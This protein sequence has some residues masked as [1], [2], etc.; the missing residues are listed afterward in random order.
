MAP[1]RCSCNHKFVIFKLISRYLYHFMWI[2]LRL[3]PDLCRHRVSLDLN[4][5]EKLYLIC[6]RLVI[7]T[8]LLDWHWGNHMIVPALVKQPWRIWV[9]LTGNQPQQNTSANH[10]LN[11]WDV[12]QLLIHWN[13]QFQGNVIIYPCFHISSYWVPISLIHLQ[14]HAPLSSASLR[15]LFHSLF[16]QP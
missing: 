10:V 3:D 7:I 12:L 16:A 2:G 6:K 4:E 14:G 9:K 15:R 1:G 13:N 8:G 5:L 11:S